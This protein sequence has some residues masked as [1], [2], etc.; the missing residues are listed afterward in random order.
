MSVTEDA[1]HAPAAA[2]RSPLRLPG[3]AR[4]A[5]PWWWLVAGSALILAIVAA[6]MAVWWLTSRETRIVSYRVVGTL[7]A[8]ELDLGSAPVQ[9]VGGPGGAVEVRREEEFAFS[10]PP[11]ET[12]KVEG[13]VLKV[14]SRCPDTVVG[15]CA[16]TYRVTVPDNVQVNV[17]TSS[18]RVAIRSL[19]ASGR[20]TTRSGPIAI[21]GFCGF[22]MIAT[23]T[24]GDVRAG[25]ACSPERLELRSSSGDVRAVVPAG[26]YRVDAHS[27]QG[28]TQV[29]GL[30]VADDASNA[31]QALSG[32]GDVTVEGGR[33]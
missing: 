18:G 26:R 21:D 5:S 14:S 15:T 20:V 31:V 13:G 7:S 6:V 2:P 28:T 12:R 25:A 19:N 3:R 8:V 9:I 17:R 4:R 32:S 23:S 29:T 10:H 33:Q 1:P 11:R 24:S 16:A 30:I 27:D 22:T